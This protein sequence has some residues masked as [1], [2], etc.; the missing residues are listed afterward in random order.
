MMEQKWGRI[1]NCTSGAFAGSV[2]HANYSAANAGVLGLTYSVAKEVWNYGITCNAFAPD[3]YTR[4]TFELEALML[5]SSK[6]KSPL[7]PDDMF[8]KMLESTPGPEE[9]APFIAY[10]ASEEAAK[11]SGSVFFVGGNNIVLYSQPEFKKSLTRAGSRWTFEELKKQA[12]MALFMGY[13][14][15][16]QP[17][18]G[19]FG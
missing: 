14:S 16:A 1:I 17:T 12:P 15:P 5:V 9:L 6:D 13:R 18:D 10:L 19:L 8:V 2:N 11:I 7:P 4:A 3:A